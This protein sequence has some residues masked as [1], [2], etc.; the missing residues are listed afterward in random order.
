MP[1]PINTL[2]AILIVY[3]FI[4]LGILFCGSA[5]FMLIKQTFSTISTSVAL[6]HHGAQA[7]AQVEDLRSNDQDSKGNEQNFTAKVTFTDSNKNPEE[8]EINIPDSV[9]KDLRARP[10]DNKFVEIK[11]VLGGSNQDVFYAYD[12][13]TGFWRF[14]SISIVMFC[15]GVVILKAG[16][17]MRK[18]L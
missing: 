16:L 12:R 17:F 4:F 1:G 3:S 13:S 15:F 14:L 9:G 18:R 2:K 6:A 8:A 10:R 7:L 5:A 11:Y